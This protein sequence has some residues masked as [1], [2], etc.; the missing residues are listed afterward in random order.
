MITTTLSTSSNWDIPTAK[1]T[2]DYYVEIT[3]GSLIVNMSVNQARDLAES[4][5]IAADA[6]CANYDAEKA[7]A[8]RT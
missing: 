5:K 2:S 4:L 1:P 6:A 8:A 7:A 3:I